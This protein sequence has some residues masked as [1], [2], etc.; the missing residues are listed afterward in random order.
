ML[1]KAAVAVKSGRPSINDRRASAPKPWTLPPW[2]EHHRDITHLSFPDSRLLSCL[3]S[4]Y[5]E[6]FNI[7]IPVLYRPSFEDG[8]ARQFHMR[9][10]GFASTLLLVLALGSLYLTDPDISTEDR[11]KLAWRWYDQVE[12]CGHSLRRQPTTYD[13]QAYCASFSI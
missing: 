10:D 5:F 8:L 9:H 6:N 2:N 7:F 12:L 1:A 13:L 4:L 11:H 3:V